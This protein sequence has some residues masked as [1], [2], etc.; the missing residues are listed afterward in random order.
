MKNKIKEILREGISSDINL[1]NVKIT[2]PSQIL[3]IMRGV[4]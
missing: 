4:P 2:R 3:I 1:L